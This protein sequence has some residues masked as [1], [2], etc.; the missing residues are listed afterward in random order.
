MSEHLCES[1][2]DSLNV[3]TWYLRF[4][5]RLRSALEGQSRGGQKSLK[6]RLESLQCLASVCVRSQCRPAALRY[7]P[8]MGFAEVAHCAGDCNVG[9]ANGIA[10]PIGSGPSTP[11]GVQHIQNTAYLG[12]T[13]LD[14][15]RRCLF[16]QS[17]LVEQAHRFVIESRRQRTDLQ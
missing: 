11:V 5:C 8:R 17:A 7:Q 12:F 1:R 13:A 10:E 15:G 4:C 2:R 3:P 6:Y 9:V 14:P 16:V